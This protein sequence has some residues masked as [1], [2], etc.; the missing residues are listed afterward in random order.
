MDTAA[1][2]LDGL[3]NQRRE[4]LAMGAAAAGIAALALIV[5]NALAIAVGVGVAAMLALAMTD[6]VRRR[7]LLALLALNPSAYIV[8]DVKRYGER[9][10][11]PR[12]RMRLAKAL[13][14]VLSEAGSPYS[15]CISGRVNKFRAELEALAASLRMP[16]VR[17]DPTSVAHCWRLLTRAAESPLYNRRLP[18]DELGFQVQRIQAGIDRPAGATD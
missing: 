14:R 2:T 16:G 9:L 11:V 4:R 10:T 3:R 8:A 18:A 5:S 7:E 12:G 15:Y 17:V 1:A 13:E 6:T